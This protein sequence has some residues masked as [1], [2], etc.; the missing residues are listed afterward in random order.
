MQRIQRWVGR[1]VVL[2][3]MGLVAH[4]P[5]LSVDSGEKVAAR[6]PAPVAELR[7]PAEIVFDGT[8]GRDQ[9]VTFRH[10]TH[11]DHAVGTCLRCHPEPFRLVRP[12]RAASHAEMD[13]GTS[14][15]RCHDGTTAFATKAESTCAICH[16]GPAT[17]GAGARDVTFGSS[18]A[19]PGPVSFR[20]AKHPASC[21]ICHPGTFVVRAGG[22]RVASP[23]DLHAACGVCHDGSAAFG[24]EDADACQRCHAAEG[25]KP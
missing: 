13:A 3:A 22:T 6:P 17:P 23:P 19:S 21:G 25:A 20:H 11:V 15:G 14:C 10:E 16:A 7:L 8:V 1:G 24:V 18:T 9:A 12:G 2:A 4:D 5:A